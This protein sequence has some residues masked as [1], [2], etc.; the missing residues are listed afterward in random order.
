MNT[1]PLP[2]GRFV[3]AVAVLLAAPPINAQ[4]NIPAN[5]MAN[6]AADRAAPI[7]MGQLGTVAVRQYQ[8]D[9]LSVSAT[10]GGA[11]LRCAFQRLEGQ[12]TPEGLWL[13]STAGRATG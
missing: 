5:G 9:G 12:A 1:T 11:R 10:P 13:H 3:L 6:H 4:T 7:P 8:G 2:L